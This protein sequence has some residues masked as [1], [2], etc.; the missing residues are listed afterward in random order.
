MI[1]ILIE[2]GSVPLQTIVRRPVGGTCYVLYDSVKIEKA[3]NVRH[4]PAVTFTAEPDLLFLVNNTAVHCITSKTMIAVDFG[5]VDEV[6][7]FLH[8]LRK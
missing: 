2:A 8:D 5:T 4:L 6:R 3:E 7:D 1:T